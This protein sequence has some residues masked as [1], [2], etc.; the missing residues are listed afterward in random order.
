MADTSIEWT[1]A[2]WNKACYPSL[3]R[4]IARAEDF[5]ERSAL[6]VV[7]GREVK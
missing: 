3:Q 4:G 2:T 5:G 6:D 7:V 1:D